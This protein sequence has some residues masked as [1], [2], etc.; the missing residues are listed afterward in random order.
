VADVARAFWLREAGVGEIRPAAVPEPGPGD[1]VVRT[2]RTGLSRGT[3]TLVFRGGVPQSQYAAMRAPFQEGDFPAPVKYGYLNVGVVESGPPEL[4]GRTVFCL[5]PH[6]TRFVVPAAAVTVVP[7]GVP[8]GRAVLAGTVETAVNAV[9]DAG[10]LL[11]DRI[12]VVGA[13]MVGCCVARLLTRFPGVT[14][15]LVDVDPS[16]A[17]VADAIGADFAEPA[18]AAGGRDLVVHTS[19]TAAGL[20]RSLE[21]LAPEG[22]VLDL[23]WYGDAEVRLSL[24]GAFHSG[25]LT[26]RSSQVGMVSPARRGRRSTADRLSLALDL[27][28]DPAFD[29]VITGESR[30]EDLPDVLRRLA[31]GELKALCHTISYGEG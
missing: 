10:P 23:S 16:R 5:Y 9:W 1:V 21:L 27:L 13:G 28:R 25:R 30:F 24:G 12:T 29:A 20:Q 3:E 18:A 6:Q 26:I 11:G 4:L 15:T 22:T 8:P 7:D 31:S 17:E 2:V 19:A 14:V